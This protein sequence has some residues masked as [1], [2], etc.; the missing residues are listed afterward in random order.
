MNVTVMSETV[1]IVTIKPREVWD[2]H[3]KLKKMDSHRILSINFWA[4]IQ[5]WLRLKDNFVRFNR[6]KGR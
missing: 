3:R 1:S 2:F 6:I 5:R 4:K